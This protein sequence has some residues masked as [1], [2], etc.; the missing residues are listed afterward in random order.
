M[1]AATMFDGGRSGGRRR[2]FA[3][4]FAGTDSDGP[5]SSTAVPAPTREPSLS[6]YQAALERTIERRERLEIRETLGTVN[7]SELLALA[8]KAAK[9]K[10]RYLAI[11]LE[12]GEDDA[13]PEAKQ[14]EAVEHARHRHEAMQ[15]A[16]AALM[17]AL[18]QAD[19]RVAG[20]AS[21]AAP[22]A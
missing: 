19:M 4:L 12:L 17:D 2:P 14:I 1:T 21:A 16:L 9:A 7:A 10:A 18:S 15:S 13:L 20:A 3:D 8:D 22:D 6:D 5:A 11:A